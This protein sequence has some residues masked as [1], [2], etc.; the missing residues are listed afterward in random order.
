MKAVVAPLLVLM[1]FAGLA[2]A[3]RAY[4]I[5]RL[6]SRV[7]AHIGPSGKVD[8][9]QDKGDFVDSTTQAYTTAPSIFAGIGLLSMLA[10]RFLP[11]QLVNVPNKD[12][13][14]AS[15]RRRWAAAMVLLNFFLWVMAAGVA[16]GVGITQAMIQATFYGEES[17]FLPVVAGFIVFLLARIALM[18]LRL[19]RKTQRV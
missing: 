8:G 3:Q 18:V 6:P 9:W 16:L 10:V 1:L 12:Y 19:S 2:I 14:L 4:Y 17:I 13:W 11:Y 7:A 5:P 15:P